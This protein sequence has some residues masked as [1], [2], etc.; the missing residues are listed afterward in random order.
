MVRNRQP[1]MSIIGSFCQAK[2]LCFI[3]A[4]RVTIMPR[5]I[6]LARR[7]RD[8]LDQILEEFQIFFRIF[9]IHTLY[10]WVQLER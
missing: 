5:D 4:K 7:I 8:N 9:T 1:F 6:A 2:I 10:Q 3:A